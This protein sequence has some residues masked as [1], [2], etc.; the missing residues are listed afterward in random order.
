MSHLP[1]PSLVLST[2]TTVTNITPG[3]TLYLLRVWYNS[4]L[5]VTSMPAL[6][7]HLYSNPLPKIEQAKFNVMHTTF[8][9]AYIHPTCSQKALLRA[10]QV[11]TAMF[12]HHFQSNLEVSIHTTH[13]PLLSITCYMFHFVPLFSQLGEG[14]SLPQLK[15]SVTVC[16][17]VLQEGEGASIDTKLVQRLLE[18]LFSHY[19]SPYQQ[20]YTHQDMEWFLRLANTSSEWRAFTHRLGVI[21]SGDSGWCA[22]SIGYYFSVPCWLLLP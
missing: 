14:Q 21:S 11:F 8:I 16:T 4:Y 15:N 20:A 18:S 17:E 1:L 6:K 9:M 22:P 13:V 3:S 5:A 7:A 12:K 19:F 10:S 2:I